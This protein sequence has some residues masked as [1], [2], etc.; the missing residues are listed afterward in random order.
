MCV[1][2]SN[3]INPNAVVPDN[4]RGRL[5]CP[6]LHASERKRQEPRSLWA[7]DIA[8]P[9]VVNPESGLR[10]LPV[11]CQWIARPRSPLV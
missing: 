2:F 1:A 6:T 8:W 4:G 11:P 3:W 7:S 9:P 5:Y 10:L